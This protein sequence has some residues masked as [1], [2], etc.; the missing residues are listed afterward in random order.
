[1]FS[2]VRDQ[3]WTG[4]GSP[5]RIDSAIADA[6]DAAHI[7]QLVETIGDDFAEEHL[8]KAILKLSAVA[9]E[10]DTGP[11]GDIVTSKS[12]KRMV[13]AAVHN[14]QVYSLLDLANIICALGRIGAEVDVAHLDYCAVQLA[15]SLPTAQPNIVSTFMWG[16][17]KLSY[18]PG[19]LVLEKVVDFFSKSMDHFMPL[20]ICE[21]VFALASMRRH[22]GSDVLQRAM[23]KI[24]TAHNLPSPMDPMTVAYLL[25]AYIV[26]NEHPGNDILVWVTGS[27]LANPHNWTGNE[28]SILVLWDF[29]NIGYFPGLDLLNLVHSGLDPSTCME[30]LGTDKVMRLLLSFSKFNYHPG[31][32]FLEKLSVTLMQY[33]ALLMGDAIEIVLWAYATFSFPP[34]QQLLWECA[35]NVERNSRKFSPVQLAN[36]L[37]AFHQFDACHSDLWSTL[38]HQ[39]HVY[40]PHA[41]PPPALLRIY[42]VYLYIQCMVPDMASHGFVPLKSDLEGQ[43]A[44]CWKERIKLRVQL[45]SG[46]A[47]ALHQEVG[48]MLSLMNVVAVEDEVMEDQLF[49]HDFAIPETKTL[50]DIV[51]PES[52][53]RNVKAPSGPAVS[54]NR[55]LQAHYKGNS[56]GWRPVSVN[57]HEWEMHKAN[58]DCQQY[59]VQIIAPD[60]K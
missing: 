5:A 56:A 45:Q 35:K 15:E 46:E 47:V 50:L 53:L 12:L 38:V 59:L 17:T 21:I 37:W 39:L 41:I 30:K 24:V 14:A 34:G 33:A 55:L 1:M 4:K 42:E 29:A 36:L 28:A 16:F 6:K 54:R 10:S 58:G 49:A 23:D 51:G 48:S 19:I 27:M 26:F 40:P 43:C 9:P 44:S 60:A 2:G 18:T 52:C 25:W 11:N 32:Q 22:P 13:L 31:E 57:F 7:F 3:V 20:S 8:L